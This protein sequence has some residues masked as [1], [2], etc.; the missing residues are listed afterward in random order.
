MSPLRLSVLLV[1]MALA[2][3]AEA[4]P[5]FAKRSPAPG[6]RQLLRQGLKIHRTLA[7]AQT[8]LPLPKSGV[9]ADSVARAKTYAQSWT[10]RES[11]RLLIAKLGEAGCRLQLD[12]SGKNTFDWGAEG[13]VS[14]HYYGVDDL[15]RP[16]VLL[17]PTASS[18]FARDAQPHGLL[19]GFL[20][21]AAKQLGQADKTAQ[22]I[23][24]RVAKGS[25]QSLLVLTRPEEIAVYKLALELAAQRRAEVTRNAE[26]AR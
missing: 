14:Y 1:L 20:G 12:S 18:N 4:R 13:K 22:K 2:A 16:T 17:D 24:R 19:H 21:D 10:C 5:L 6:Q 3:S 8:P 26:R 7:K 15:R 23:A 11:S 9:L 25:A